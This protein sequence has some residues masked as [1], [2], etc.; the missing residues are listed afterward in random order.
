MTPNGWKSHRKNQIRKDKAGRRKAAKVRPELL[1]GDWRCYLCGT[2][3]TVIE[4]GH[5][6]PAAE[7]PDN[8]FTVDHV[9]PVS[10]GGGNTPDNRRACCWK[11]NRAKANA[12]PS[13]EF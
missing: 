12:M 5:S 11:C 3:L 13:G 8:L 2:R 10:R 6:L 7:K 4:N 1:T 9:V